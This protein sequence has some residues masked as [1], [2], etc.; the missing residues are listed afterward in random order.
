MSGGD[1]DLAGFYE[2][3][4]RT[5]NEHRF[6]D[7]GAFV[8][9]DVE[10]DDEPVGLAVYVDGLR[11]LVEGF[12]DYRWH[13]RHLL[14]DGDL[15]SA[16]FEDTGRHLG[17]LRHLGPRW[18][19]PA[20]GRPVRVQ[21]FAVYRVRDGQIRQVWARGDDLAVVEQLTRD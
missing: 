16:H 15:V 17:Q 5:C 7:L 21:E 9:D 3:Y 18:R 4:L 11:A 2:R 6:D 8:A 13:L 12:P 19:L 1:E 14:V 10:V 20:T